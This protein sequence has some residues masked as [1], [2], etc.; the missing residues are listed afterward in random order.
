MTTNT[1]RPRIVIVGGGFGGL[2]LAKQLKDQPVEVVM[3]D[4]HN[5]HTFQPLLYQV[6][7]GALD[8]ETITFPFRRIFQD[9]KNF[10]FSLAEVFKINPEK[11]TV[12]TAIGDVSYDY[13][14][15]ATGADTN[16]FGNKQLEH[17]SM[18]MKSV[19]EAMNIRS[20]ILQSFEAALSEKDPGEK[21]ELMTFVIVGGGPTGVELAGALAEFK[22]HILQKDYPKLDNCEM[23]VFVVEGKSTVLGVMSDKASDKAQKY[24]QDMGVI[25][26]NDVHVK[27]FDGELLTIDD[28]KELRTRNVLWAAGVAGQFPEGISEEN[29]VKGRRLQTDEI[30]KIKGYN[31]IFAIGDVAA[32]T[33]ADT[34]NGYPGVAQ[35]ALQQGKQLAKNLIA[36]IEGK[37]TVPFKYKDK[38]SMATIGRNKAV[39]DIGKFKFAGFFAWLLWCFVH[40]FSLVGIQ[41]KIAV[42]IM[43]FGRYFTY[44]GPSR[45]IIRPFSRES[46]TE[47][48][49]A[50]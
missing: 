12:E 38:G 22:T 33:T 43:W 32:V 17:F 47:N 5:Y 14:V 36:I 37:A 24:L 23:R 42:F 50:K 49:A 27:S 11:N 19:P 30:N 4:R 39:A 16:F 3:L 45:I 35:V 10:S 8:A 25:I 44:N 31:N 21:E 46:M 2:E 6:A 34:P 40:V 28:G 7:T 20:M 48:T 1:E 15:L 9:Q 13:L 26:Y 41:N 18:G 29:I